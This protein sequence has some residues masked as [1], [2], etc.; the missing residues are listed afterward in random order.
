MPGK[1]YPRVGS[2]SPRE[3]LR[4]PCFVS[5]SAGTRRRPS[6]VFLFPFRAQSLRWRPYSTPCLGLFSSSLAILGSYSPTSPWASFIPL[7][8]VNGRPP[9]MYEAPAP[10]VRFTR[11]HPPK[12]HRRAG[13]PSQVKLCLS[14]RNYTQDTEHRL[15]HGLQANTE[16]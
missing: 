7:C 2:A 5:P 3:R 4:F 8:S 1:V 12:A 6:G 11:F 13:H 14:S 15:T 10:V 9:L 16:T